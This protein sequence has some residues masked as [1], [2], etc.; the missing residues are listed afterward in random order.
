MQTP[1]TSD[2]HE[3]PRDE[4]VL[5]AFADAAEEQDT[6]EWARWIEKG[7]QHLVACLRRDTQDPYVLHNWGL[8][9]P[10]SSGGIAQF[11]ENGDL[12]TP[13][14]HPLTPHPDFTVVVNPSVARPLGFAVLPT[15]ASEQAHEWF[16]LPHRRFSLMPN[17]A[18]IIAEKADLPPR[19]DSATTYLWGLP[20]TGLITE[21][22]KGD[23][24]QAFSF[25]VARELG[26]QSVVEAVRQLLAS[27]GR[28]HVKISVEINFGGSDNS[29]R[30][31]ALI[32]LDA[33]SKADQRLRVKASLGV[34][35][36]DVDA[37]TFSEFVRQGTAQGLGGIQEIEEAWTSDLVTF[38]ESKRRS[39][40][41]FRGP[42]FEHPTLAE[43]THVFC[44]ADSKVASDVA[45]AFGHAHQRA[46]RDGIVRKF[47][48]VTSCLASELRDQM[49]VLR[50]ADPHQVIVVHAL[51]GHAVL[52]REVVSQLPPSLRPDGFTATR[53]EAHRLY[54][55][56]GLPSDITC[57]ARAVGA[58]MSSPGSLL[59]VRD[60]LGNQQQLKKW[61]ATSRAGINSSSIP[62]DVA[63][64]LDQ[65]RNRALPMRDRDRYLSRADLDPANL[66]PWVDV[67]AN[68]S[69]DSFTML[70][71]GPEN[72]INQAYLYLPT[73]SANLV[74]SALEGI[75]PKNTHAWA[76]NFGAADP[77]HLRRCLAMFGRTG[78]LRIL[79]GRGRDAQPVLTALRESLSS[80]EDPDTPTLA[81]NTAI[82]VVFQDLDSDDHKNVAAGLEEL[83]RQ[84][85]ASADPRAIRIR[86][87]PLAIDDGQILRGAE[88]HRRFTENPVAMD[89]LLELIRSVGTDHTP[90]PNVA[91]GQEVVP[92]AAAALNAKV[93][94]WEQ[95]LPVLAGD[96]THAP[97]IAIIC[98]DE[99]TRN[100]IFPADVAQRL[101]NYDTP[102]ASV[103]CAPS[104]IGAI[105]RTI[106][107][108]RRA[109]GSPPA[110]FSAYSFSGN[111]FQAYSIVAGL[112]EEEAPHHLTVDS[113]WLRGAVNDRSVTPRPTD[114]PH[115]MIVGTFPRRLGLKPDDVIKIVENGFRGAANGAA[116]RESTRHAYDVMAD[117]AHE[118]HN[119]DHPLANVVAALNA[120]RRSPVGLV[121]GADHASLTIH[122]GRP[123][124]SIYRTVVV[125]DCGSADAVATALNT[126]MASIKYGQATYFRPDPG[127]DELFDL[128]FQG[129]AP[130][131]IIYCLD[132]S[133]SGA[134]EPVIRAGAR[135]ARLLGHNAPRPGMQPRGV[136][137]RPR[138]TAA[139]EELAQVWARIGHQISD[140]LPLFY[141]LG[142]DDP[143]PLSILTEPL[144]TPNL[145]PDS[146]YLVAGAELSK[147]KNVVVLAC[148]DRT[149]TS[150]QAQLYY[151]LPNP[152]PDHTA[153]IASPARGV[154]NFLRKL[155]SLAGQP[156]V[157]IEVLKEA[158]L[159]DVVATS[160]ERQLSYASNA[161]EASTEPK[162]SRYV[163]MDGFYRRLAY[164]FCDN[165]LKPAGDSDPEPAPSVP[166]PEA[167]FGK[168]IAGPH[169]REAKRVVVVCPPVNEPRVVKVKAMIGEPDPGVAYV[170]PSA[171]QIP[172][173]ITSLDDDLT[174][175]V[176]VLALPGS[177]TSHT[178][179]ALSGL[180]RDELDLRY[181]TDLPPYRTNV[182][183]VWVHD[184]EYPSDAAHLPMPLAPY[185]MQKGRLPRHITRPSWRV[186]QAHEPQGP[187]WVVIACDEWGSHLPEPA[188]V[189]H[190]AVATLVAQAAA[191]DLAATVIACRPENLATT[192]AQASEQFPDVPIVVATSPER[193]IATHKAVTRLSRHDPENDQDLEAH[194]VVLPSML[195]VPE[196]V[197][198]DAGQLGLPALTS[199]AVLPSSS[200]HRAAMVNW[201][202]R[203]VYETA[204]FGGRLALDLESLMESRHAD[205]LRDCV[206][207]SMGAIFDDQA[208]SAFALVANTSFIH[209]PHRRIVVSTLAPQ[210]DVSATID[211]W[212]GDYR[213]GP[214]WVF[215]EDTLAGRESAATLVAEL[216]TESVSPDRLE[217]IGQDAAAELVI[218][219]AR[220]YIAVAEVGEAAE[221]S[222][223]PDVEDE[224]TSVESPV[225]STP[226]TTHVGLEVTETPAVG[227][228]AGAMDETL[229]SPVPAS[230]PTR[231]DPHGPRV[232]GGDDL[233]VH[234][235]PARKTDPPPSRK[236]AAVDVSSTGR[237][238]VLAPDEHPQR[239]VIIYPRRP[240]VENILADRAAAG[241]KPTAII[242]TNDLGGAL[243]T[244]RQI[245][246]SSPVGLI[247]L[248]GRGTEVL[249][250][251]I[252]HAR[253]KD[254]HNIPSPL[255]TFVITSSV[256]IAAHSAGA[257]LVV[258]AQDAV[259]V[260]Q[261]PMTQNMPGKKTLERS[262]IQ[263]ENP[264][265]QKPSSQKRTP[266]NVSLATPPPKPKAYVRPPRQEHKKTIGNVIALIPDDSPDDT[267][268][269]LDEITP[270]NLHLIK[271]RIDPLNYATAYAEE[272]RRLR[273]PRERTILLVPSGAGET[274]SVAMRQTSS[275]LLP[276]LVV[277]GNDE[278][279]T[280]EDDATWPIYLQ[281][282]AVT[283]D[284]RLGLRKFV[285]SEEAFMASRRLQTIVASGVARLENEDGATA[286]V[287]EHFRTLT[288]SFAAGNPGT[289]SPA[290]LG[291]IADVDDTERVTGFITATGSPVLAHRHRDIRFPTDIKTALQ[292]LPQRRANAT[293]GTCE[294]LVVEQISPQ[295]LTDMALGGDSPIRLNIHLD[296][297]DPKLAEIVQTVDH[298]IRMKIE[299]APETNIH[300]SVSRDP[301]E[302]TH[303]MSGLLGHWQRQIGVRSVHVR[304]TVRTNDP[305]GISDPDPKPAAMPLR[306]VT[307]ANPSVL[308]NLKRKVNEPPVSANATTDLGGKETRRST[309]PPGQSQT[310][311]IHTRKEL[312]HQQVSRRKTRSSTKISSGG[313]VDD[314]QAWAIALI[315][316]EMPGSNA[317]ERI[318]QNNPYDALDLVIH[319]APAAD[320]PALY[321]STVD[322]YRSRVAQ[323]PIVVIVPKGAEE[324][325]FQ[326]L[327][328]DPDGVS[329]ILFAQPKSPT[330]ID[331]FPSL[332]NEIVKYPAGT[333][334]WP[335]QS[336]VK[337]LSWDAA[338]IAEFRSKAA[339]SK[340]IIEQ[341]GRS[342]ARVREA[343]S[344]CSLDTDGR[345][346]KRSVW[347]QLAVVAY[348]FQGFVAVS[349]P[350]SLVKSRIHIVL[351]EKVSDLVASANESNTPGNCVARVVGHVPARFLGTLI[352]QGRASR[353]RFTLT[354]GHRSTKEAIAAV[355]AAY[356]IDS[357]GRIARVEVDIVGIPTPGGLLAEAI[358]RWESPDNQKAPDLL[359]KVHDKEEREPSK[360]QSHGAAPEVVLDK[361][362]RTPRKSRTLRITRVG[363]HIRDRSAVKP[364][365][366]VV[367]Q[368][369]EYQHQLAVVLPTTEPELSLSNRWSA[370]LQ[371]RV[372]VREIPADGWPVV[373]RQMLAE[374][375]TRH[376]SVLSLGNGALP[377]LWAGLSA[378]ELP[379]ATIS[380]RHV[381]RELDSESRPPT[382]SALLENPTH[383]DGVPAE[384]PGAIELL[385][386]ELNLAA[387]F[388]ADV[389]ATRELM[390]SAD[391]RKQIVEML[392]QSGYD[393]PMLAAAFPGP[394]PLS[395]FRGAHRN[396]V[397]VDTRADNSAAGA[398]VVDQTLYLAPKRTFSLRAQPRALV[399]TSIEPVG[400]HAAIHIVGAASDRLL[401][402][403]AA[404]GQPS[405]VNFELASH[406]ALES[407][408]MVASDLVGKIVANE[409]GPAVTIDVDENVMN[410]SRSAPTTVKKWLQQRHARLSIR[411]NH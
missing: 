154:K 9:H 404:V 264:P 288:N 271:S 68:D 38:A 306:N 240:G 143:Q 316:D 400:A 176:S 85:Q 332:P 123:Q 104:D 63:D 354:E 251:V 225:E 81:P 24:A 286:A 109:I 185:T 40:Q 174:V 210:T 98:D 183:V 372:T 297:H 152:L 23:N 71:S 317:L 357:P 391:L 62:A 347:D 348:N 396:T 398:V 42:R 39:A 175:L 48:E 101:G 130:D 206:N 333:K 220:D 369:G 191:M 187:S 134:A 324:N 79:I 120:S 411:I 161:Q 292:S 231:D 147:A 196:S 74:S 248:P 337:R 155:P 234:T 90:E 167:E 118:V 389:M 10:L 142:D 405:Q 262:F 65:L 330:T 300:I 226:K 277:V 287:Q 390:N 371:H 14:A 325:V 307:G 363:E 250:Y 310:D 236:L 67:V 318:I 193:G 135:V 230:A 184:S 222:S 352:A 247:A 334:M 281:I 56:N 302:S 336:A 392:A 359:F 245:A 239:V 233:T 353:V 199:L 164:R 173:V 406:P 111:N 274:A 1:S 194:G 34:N 28:A 61:L 345:V 335:T 82:T 169:P 375:D 339:N 293:P 102:I 30:E 144:K 267:E 395:A 192:V 124:Q 355:D 381:L 265:A 97:N 214:A 275:A 33:L 410:D 387:Q 374:A 365:L 376:T 45:T 49:R 358:K 100:K 211:D 75:G 382:W 304:K 189:S 114:L 145:A 29:S 255:P 86:V 246:P 351:N 83:R 57:Q 367:G 112:P 258:E 331:H 343:L 126:R 386:R 106:S 5:G 31:A 178:N 237:L 84:V 8:L 401:A 7:Q 282:R 259:D 312:S 17:G 26:A 279:A 121:F 119:V 278:R 50:G 380:D 168:H 59:K 170:Y 229:A 11:A 235:E 76:I 18:S 179:L 360:R 361:R 89:R 205:S 177:W 295:L 272:V 51:D 131:N 150:Y 294:M 266:D 148:S 108:Q 223:V 373:Y 162:V 356:G 73:N 159:N 80:Q 207:G 21:L 299:L 140:N 342:M 260:Y 311:Q 309:A 201:Y 364:Q 87:G 313:G 384:G 115:S 253:A 46:Q 362:E 221:G 291:L 263:I 125:A 122:T 338:E 35:S 208:D 243:A 43:I 409:P 321:R 44:G 202:L 228:G 78:N 366:P 249:E 2:D 327:S 326:I 408:M 319:R 16:E 402:D 153:V 350:P 188:D 117:S 284:H 136:T 54:A 305:A 385:M 105:I 60:L 238:D 52:V 368:S 315:P 96:T 132:G 94:P 203:M 378:D 186:E 301:T 172:Q 241:S 349:S 72:G 77:E 41:T 66:S 377:R 163:P 216:A 138:T 27:P 393:T 341:F 344:N 15:L 283:I 166:H 99:A 47:A 399:A 270:L 298:L 64:L 158:D 198:R 370:A 20:D 388:R 113:E 285:I 157:H 394:A 53:D 403:A 93:S 308:R 217:L 227:R 92:A 224:P 58:Y 22:S 12:F 269:L 197:A 320:L 133:G 69:L 273:D 257:A 290:A 95:D 195:L 91:L 25:T 32:Q 151:R 322:E 296:Y 397:L 37:H 219:Q 407:T 256:D 156:D 139:V 103:H 303:E 215:F 6:A 13:A 323:K 232:D 261:D 3:G 190:D 379:T 252:E 289:P 329:A 213:S 110:L 340:L 128:G 137:I 4:E 149:F 55:F 268:A 36:E 127:E 328:N 88:P 242:A 244:A 19:L 204:D 129:K 180:R 70:R 182:D 280:H 146:W 218:G 160:I 209:A 107:A 212:D 346:D 171:K 181:K 200:D 276:D 116:L 141:Q 383:F 254:E 314:V 165:E